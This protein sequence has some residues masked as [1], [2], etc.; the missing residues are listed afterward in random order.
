MEQHPDQLGCIFHPSDDMPNATNFD[1]AVTKF[2]FKKVVKALEA[3]MPAADDLYA[4]FNLCP[5]MIAASFNRSDVSIIYHLL[6]QVPSLVNYI[7][8]TQDE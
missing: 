3:C 6:R 8:C 7:N 2:G 1:R 4:I 5:F